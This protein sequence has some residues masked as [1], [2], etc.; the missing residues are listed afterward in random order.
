MNNIYNSVYA[1]SCRKCFVLAYVLKEF[2]GILINKYSKIYACVKL[3][4]VLLFKMRC[5][6]NSSSYRY[7][8]EWGCCN[9][10]SVSYV[11]GWNRQKSGLLLLRVS[12]DIQQW[13]LWRPRIMTQSQACTLSYC[14]VI[15]NM[16]KKMKCYWNVS[17]YYFVSFKHDL[18]W[19]M[20]PSPH[21]Y[22]LKKIVEFMFEAI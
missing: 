13:E 2:E 14:L 7:N 16:G 20:I 1:F 15:E 6:L 18:Q 8:N 12:T 21:S 11:E 10:I 22:V 5:C 9:C 17:R 4:P 19:F 3:V